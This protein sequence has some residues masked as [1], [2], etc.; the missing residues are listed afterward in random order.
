[1]IALFVK[2]KQATSHCS[3]SVSFANRDV[4]FSGTGYIQ[5]TSVCIAAPFKKKRY[6][7]CDWRI[8]ENIF[9]IEQSALGYCLAALWCVLCGLWRREKKDTGMGRAGRGWDKRRGKNMGLV[10]NA[11]EIPNTRTG[12]LPVTVALRVVVCAFTQ[13]GSGPAQ[14]SVRKRPWLRQ[15]FWRE[16]LPHHLLCM[17]TGSR[18]SPRFYETEFLAP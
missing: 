4:H 8:P 7:L 13:M 12:R 6:Y 3:P 11:K 16:P 17:S 5:S 1:M 9:Q 10:K 15:A 18:S 2:V 14:S